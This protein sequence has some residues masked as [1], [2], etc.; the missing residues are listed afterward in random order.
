MQ[1]LDD[2]EAKLD[3]QGIFQIPPL[4]YNNVVDQII[5]R[6][7]IINHL[8]NETMRNQCRSEKLNRLFKYGKLAIQPK[9]IEH[10]NNDVN[11]KRKHDNSIDNL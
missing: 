9:E 5:D 8:E 11:K 4:T 1:R 3:A 7:L 6:R 2:A 10:D